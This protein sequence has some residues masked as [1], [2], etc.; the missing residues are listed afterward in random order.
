VDSRTIQEKLGMERLREL[1]RGFS[2]VVITTLLSL[3]ALELALRAVDAPPEPVWGWKWDRSPYKSDMGDNRVNELG[4]R[5]RSIAYDPNDFVIVLV[6]DS[7]VEAGAQAYDDMPEHILENLLRTKY[8]I[9]HVKVFS[10]ASAGWGQDQELLWLSEYFTR[11]R[12]NLVLTWLTPINDYWENGNID[13][14]ASLHAGPLKPTFK[15]TKDNNLELE[16]P[17]RFRFKLRLLVEKAIAKLIYGDGPALEQLYT[18]QWLKKL[19][20]SNLTPVSS[21]L[22]PLFVVDQLEVV[23]SFQR[24]E[25]QITA[26]TT[27][28]LSNSRSHFSHFLVP[29]SSRER[30]QIHITHRLIEET[31]QLSRAHGAAFRAFYPEGSDI[32]KALHS[33]KCVKDQNTGNYYVTNFSDLT[34]DL[35]SSPLHNMLVTFNINSDASTGISSRDWHLNRHGNLLAMD[36][37]AQQLLAQN[38]LP[39]GARQ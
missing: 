18:D 16:Y 21:S 22:C 29:I 7:Y 12:A 14:S 19:P 23:S 37:L 3:A 34:F 28:D 35:K 20:Q 13:R 2:I 25:T 32:D 33:V 39:H 5:G 30:Y 36:A 17:P 8:G 11:F 10:I 31:A 27:E 38:V 9:D 6:G 26:L 24:G 1:L 4:L 15:L